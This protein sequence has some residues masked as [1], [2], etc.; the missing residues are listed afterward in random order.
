MNRSRSQELYERSRRLMPGGVSSPV[1]AFEPYPS[2]I[3]RASGSRLYDVDGNELI[4]YCMGFGPHILGHAHSAVVKAVQ[5]Q[6]ER[7][8]LYGAPT[9]L[10]LR[11]AET[12][13]RCFPSMEMMRFVSSGTE[14]TMHALR[15]ARGV[16]GRKLIVKM[17]GGFHGA[18]DSVL[19]KAGSGAATHSA[20]DSAGVPEEA[21]SNTLLAPYNDIE[22]VESL[23]LSNKGRVAA[24]I[25]EPVLGNIG[26]VEPDEG[27]LPRL[28]EVTEE[29]GALLIFDEVITGFRL[30]MGG[31]QSRFNVRPDITTLG[32][33]LGGG[34]PIGAFGARAEIMEKVSPLGPVYQAGT[35]AGNPLSMAAGLA[36]LKELGSVGHEGL[37]R[38]GQ[39]M[40]SQLAALLR[41]HRLPFQVAGVGSMFQIFMVDRPV[42]DHRDAMAADAKRF[43]RLFHALLERGVYI[44]PSQYETCFLSTAHSDEDINRT[45]NAYDEALEAIQ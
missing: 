39:V 22:A 11:M 19:V 8:T 1:R 36:A 45:V 31:A 15:L 13:R 29:H 27:Y 32:K 43:M 10:E 3:Q 4:D 6:A 28:R 42:R 33:V 20:P 44:P 17:K 16:T 34:L 24:V 23:L 40:R 9:E 2:F 41:E 21:A 7:G 25:V 35:F 37:E 5:Q 18:H 12:V 14:A 30:S 26:P 38:K